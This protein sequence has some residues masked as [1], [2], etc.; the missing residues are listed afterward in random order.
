M[1]TQSKCK[2]ICVKVLNTEPDCETLK[3][4][5]RNIDIKSIIGLKKKPVVI[6]FYLDYKF[7]IFKS[8]FNKKTFEKGETVTC[9]FNFYSRKYKII[10]ELQSTEIFDAKPG[11]ALDGKLK[12]LMK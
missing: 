12:I 9:N 6:I 10:C 3:N 1:S 8:L 2:C 11:L 7:L 5:V 4:S